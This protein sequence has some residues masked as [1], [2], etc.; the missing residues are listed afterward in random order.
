MAASTVKIN[1]TVPS[2]I[3]AAARA[4]AGGNLSAYTTEA[5]RAALLRDALRRLTDDGHTGLPD[6]VAA[7]EEE[8][9]AP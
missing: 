4:A 9:R 3:A 8:D 5:L 2:D 6:D 7:A 1:V